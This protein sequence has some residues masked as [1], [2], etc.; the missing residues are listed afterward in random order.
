MARTVKA[1]LLFARIAVLLLPAL[2]PQ[3]RQS[4]MGRTR[5]HLELQLQFVVGP[6][7]FLGVMV[8]IGAPAILVCGFGFWLAF[9]AWSDFRKRS[10]LRQRADGVYVWSD[11]QG[12]ERWSVTDP[13]APG[14]EWA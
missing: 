11:W 12:K 6:I 2:L 8:S 10:T 4:M 9:H 5:A 13:S 3:S 1:I 7:L 14:G